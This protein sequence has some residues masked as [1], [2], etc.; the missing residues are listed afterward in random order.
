MIG[1]FTCICR[2]GYSGSG[3][4]C[5]DVDECVER[6]PCNSQAEC[7]NIDGSFTCMCDDGFLG[8][9]F[10]CTDMNECLGVPCH[11]QANCVN[12]F[13]SYQCFCRFG[14]TGDGFTCDEI[15]GVEIPVNPCDA[16]PCAANA[17]CS[18][19]EDDAVCRCKEGFNGNPTVFCA[20]TCSF[21]EVTEAGLI[22]TFNSTV[23]DFVVYSN[24]FCPAGFPQA[25]ITCRA[26]P[27]TGVVRP[28]FA[29]DTLSYVNCT[30]DTI[31]MIV[32]EANF[33]SITSKDI[34]QVL[35]ELDLHTSVVDQVTNEETMLIVNAL[36]D[37][38]NSTDDVEVT[39]SIFRKVVSISDHVTQKLLV[40]DDDDTASSNE[41]LLNADEEV[42][43][44]LT[45]IGF[46]VQ[47]EDNQTSVSIR[48]PN[49]AAEVVDQTDVTAATEFQ[50]KVYT[51]ES[52]TTNE[53]QPVA[54][55][56][57]AEALEIARRAETT[58]IKKRNVDGTNSTSV[59]VVFL[60]HRTSELFPSAERANWVASADVENQRING[61]T[62]PVV[63]KHLTIN[64]TGGRMANERPF[65]L[66]YVNETCAFWN[67]STSSWSTD[68]CCLV[69]G[70]NPPE[71]RCNHL[72]NFAMLL[73]I[74]DIPDDVVLSTLT[75]VG[76]SISIVFLAFTFLL[77]VVPKHIRNRRPIKVL[78]NVC[79]NL[80]LAYVVFLA[81]MDKRR[82]VAGCIASAVLLHYFLLCTWCWMAVYSH[83]LYKS[84]VQVMGLSWQR[85]LT[86]T[87]I[88]SYGIPLIIVAVNTAVTLSVSEHPDT[89]AM[90]NS[91]PD[92]EM[93]VSAMLADNMCWLH[94]YSLYFSFLLPVG[95]VLIFN[96]VVFYLVIRNITWNRKQVSS[97]TTKKT[98]R[99][100]LL[101]AVT[102]ASTLGLVW[103]LGYFLLLSDNI[104]YF[105]IM[106]WLFTLA[107][108]F[109]GFCL[110][111]L[112]CVR[113]GDV[114]DVWWP[115]AYR[116]LCCPFKRFTSSSPKYLT[117]AQTR[118]T[119]TRVATVDSSSESQSH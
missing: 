99:Q 17:T 108:S 106:N 111:L 116:F 34:E 90:C 40:L 53:F 51:D 93:A 8:D 98:V 100:Q 85:Y 71:C 28:F 105:T 83:V 55:S 76:C 66:S 38:S 6:S 43:N 36:V 31:A 3:Q 101:V 23:V 18:W 19:I 102:I 59:R 37:L 113:K 57:P 7:H 84:F 30:N 13:G 68:G 33:A 74:Y 62:D 10:T 73:A 27:E 109:Q 42:L 22:F 26:F 70:S 24:E 65:T 81:G 95:L 69:D 45:T 80:M 86:K 25:S 5:L 20:A 29:L 103:L 107:A 46:H 50:P 72:T 39:D 14:Y 112:L 79:I 2:D 118:K 87:F 11:S 77:L 48:T 88:A 49:I 117:T 44:A 58:R 89:P 1:S 47:L 41:T 75:T 114:R 35:T 115:T 91:V 78:I 67:F 119:D 96:L 97:S 54:I 21:S 61:L 4:D 63:I 12:T 9:G 32:S 110:F 52:G 94:G 60:A 82:Q 15:P 92:S 64:V 104:T 56:V 16:D